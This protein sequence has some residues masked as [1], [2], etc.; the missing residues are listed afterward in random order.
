[1]KYN[2]Y[3]NLRQIWRAALGCV[4]LVMTS[5][6][7]VSQA[8][9]AA[10]DNFADAFVLAGEFGST[11]VDTTGF[12]V[13]GGEPGH[14]GFPAVASGWFK[15]TAPVSG[16]V[17]FETYGSGIDTVLAVYTTGGSDISRLDF[18]VAND[19]ATPAGQ[20][21]PQPAIPLLQAF[22]GNW[23]GPSLVKFNAKGGQTYYV[24]V[25]GK[26]GAQ[27]AVTLNWAYHSAGVFRFTTDVLTVS[28][29]D[30]VT[31][32]SSGSTVR[33]VR[34][35]RVTVTRV[36]GS[37]GR[38][39][40]DL[41]S[42]LTNSTVT[43]V[44][45]DWEMSKSVI[46]PIPNDP[47]SFDNT[48][49][50][51]TLSNPQLDPLE[52]TQILPP[53]IDP[54]HGV[55]TVTVLNYQYDPEDPNLTMAN[56]ERSTYRVREDVGTATIRIN[57]FGDP[58]SKDIHV[59][60]DRTGRGAPQ[61]NDAA[62]GLEAGSDYATPTDP[63]EFAPLTDDP[64]DFSEINGNAYGFDFTFGQ[65]EMFRDI[66]IPINNDT[67]PEFA[68]DIKVRIFRV[69]GTSTTFP[70]EVFETTITIMHDD[71]PAGA[72]DADH[73]P[74]FSLLTDP[75]RNSTPGANGTVLAA[76]VQ[77]D[78]K[79]V[80]GGNFTKFNAFN[81]KM[82]ARLN[83]DGSHD[84]SFN[85]GSGANDFIS[86]VS[87]ASDGKIVIGGKFTSYNG[88][89][90]YC[91]ARLND[92]GSLDASFNP[93][94]GASD[95][96]W[97]LAQQPDGKILI[98]G[99][100]TSVNG[101]TRAYIAR[102]NS[103]GS[104]DTTFNPTNALNG[105][106][107]T[108]AVAADGTIYVGGQFTSAGGVSRNYVARLLADGSLDAAFDPRTGADGPVEAL[109][110]QGDGKPVI[111]GTFD[112]VDLRERRN[113]A[114]LN[115]DGTLD[116]SFDPGSGADDSV[117]A[118]T[119][120]PDGR[121]FIGGAFLNVNGT[122][123]VGVARLFTDGKV[124]T[125]FMDTAYNHF[126]GIFTHYSTEIP[127][128]I[129]EVRN[130]LFTLALQADG[131]LMIGGSFHQVGGGRLHTSIQTNNFDFMRDPQPQYDEVL[132][133]TFG[134]SR[135]AYRNRYNIARL[136]GGDTDGPGNV[137]FVASNTAIDE[138]AGF[139]SVRTVR[140]RGTLGPVETSFALPP[141]TSG[142]GV[143][144]ATTD[145]SYNHINPFF[146]TTWVGGSS[147]FTT[148]NLSD[149]M[150]GTNNIE[151]RV[152]PQTT[153][154]TTDD[155][156]LTIARNS[157][158]QGDRVGNMQLSVP[159]QADVFFLG[160]ENVPLASALGRS[161]ASLQI[162]E[163]DNSP[164]VIG[165][166]HVAYTVNENGGN[167][168]IT[169]T[170]TNGSYGPVSVT[171]Y[172]LNGTAVAGVNY[173]AKTNFS[174]SFGDG[175]TNNQT[176]NIAIQNNPAI[177]PDD[178]TVLLRLKSPTGGATLGQTNA[179]LSIID[180]D[181]QAG[182]LN[183]T[184]VA[185]SVQEYAG[186]ARVTVTRTGGNLGLEDVTVA[187]QN[188]T[189][190]AGVH[191][192]GLTNSLHWD[193]GDTTSRNIDI[194]LLPD[195]LVTANLGFNVR[196][197]NAAPAGALGARTN[198]AVTILNGDFYGSPQFSAANYYF[199]ET[200]GYATITV[201]RTGGSAETISVNYATSDGSAVSSGPVP[202]FVAT[203]GTL[204]FGPGVVS[205]TLTVPILDDGTP[206]SPISF[207]VNLSGVTPGGA[208]L[209]SPSLAAVNIIDAQSF[210]QPAGS[211][212][213]V[214]N[215]GWGFN[216][217]VYALTLQPSGMIVAGGDFTT[218]NGLPQ[219][220]LARLNTNGSPDT[221][222]M[223]GLNGANGAVRA[224]IS[225]SNNRLVVGG[226]FTT[227]NSVNRNNV[228][229]LNTDGTLDT[230][231][232]PGSGADAPVYALAESA[233]EGSRRLYIGGGFNTFNGITSPGLVRLHDNGVVDAAF[234]VAVGVNGPVYAV[235]VYATNTIQAGK[236]VIGGAFTEVNGV[237]RANIA[238]L[239]VDG[240]LDTTFNPGS[241]ANAEVRSV[242]LQ[243]DGKV[244]IGGAF[245]DVAGTPLNRIAR[246]NLN[247][248]VDN[249]F[250]IGSGCNEAVYAVA[251][252]ADNR[253]LVAGDFT[254]ASGVTRRRITRLLPDGQV[255]PTI[256]FG[257]GANAF[258][259]AVLVQ[260]DTHIVLGG[261]FTSIQGQ[262]AD[263]IARIFGGAITGPGQVEFSSPL[264]VVNEDG[265]NAVITLRR[266]L[267]TSGTN[268]DGTGTVT[269]T[270]STGDNSAIAGINYTA[271]TQQVNFPVGEVEAT[272]VVPV[273]QDFQITSDLLATLALSGDPQGPQ[274]TALLQIVNV[275]SAV[276]FSSATYARNEDAIDG[277][278]TITIVREGSTAGT[279]T[280]I[281]DTTTNGT[282]VAGVNYL[283]VTNVT[284]TFLPGES[285]R[286]VTVPLLH[287][288][289][290]EGN[291]TV[292][293]ALSVPTGT[294]LLN[295]SSAI[296]TINDVDQA[297]GT[298]LFSQAAYV[299]SEGATNAVITVVRS[300]GVTGVV[301]V[302]INTIPG[303]A[304]P[305]VR[306]V[307]T[308]GVLTFADGQSVRTFSIGLIDDNIVQGDQSLLVNL[309]GATGGAT[310]SEPT[311]VSLTILDNDVAV[312]FTSP[313]YVVNETA[314]IV[315]LGVQRL[316]GSNGTV[317]V[318]FKTVN[319]TAIAGTNYTADN[320]TLTFSPG[321]VLKTVGI[322]VQR[323]PR[324]TGN[325]S[326][327]AVLSNASAGVQLVAPNPAS[328]IIVDNDP[329]I[330][331]TN[332]T[333]SILESGT[334]LVVTVIR[335]NANSGDVSVNFATADQTAVAGQDYTSTSGILTFL[336]GETE[337]TI[338]IP[339]LDNQ[340]V[341]SDRTFLVNLF[342]PTGGAQLTEPSSIVATIVDNDAG[343]RFST[344]LYQVFENGVQAT[345]TVLR[346][347]YTNSAVSVDYTTQDGTGIAGT[348]YTATSGTLLFTNGETVKT[349]TVGI[350]DDSQLTGD[351]TVLLKLQN[352]Q[353][354]AAIINPGAATLNIS[355]DDG[356]L[357]IPAGT[358]LV[359]EATNNGV[360]DPGETLTV[361]FGFRN[362]GGTNAVNMTA[363]LLSSN[364][365]LP[366]TT[367][368]NYGAMVVGAPVKSRPY[369]FVAN[370]TNGQTIIANFALSDNG[371]PIGSGLFTFTLGSTTLS[372]TNGAAITITDRG[373]SPAPLGATPYPSTIN[374]N[375]ALGTISKVTVTLSNY[376]HMSSGDVGALLVNPAGQKTL[377]MANCG[378]FNNVNN[379]WLQFDDAA[380]GSLSS[381][382]APTSGAYKPT[383]FA[384][385]PPFPAPAPAGT[386]SNS[387]A[388]F[389]GGNPNG[390][391]SLFVLD[392]T[393]PGAGS[394]ANGWSL[395]I[396]RSSSIP[397]ASDLSLGMTATPQP[398]IAA[399]QLTYTLW[400]TNN[401]P[402]TATSVSVADTLPAGVS[403]VSATTATGGATNVSGVVTWT[404]GSMAN[405]ATAS[406]ALTVIPS[407][408]GTITNTAVASS[409]VS[410]LFTQNNTA[411]LV[412]AVNVPSAD[413]VLGMNDSPDPVI[414]GAPLTY[415]ITVTN[416][417]PATATGVVVTNPLLAGLNFTSV[418]ASQGTAG[419]SGG[420]V[421]A[422]LGSISSG[423]N[424]S[425]TLV[426][427]VGFV[428]TVTNVAT[429]SSP[430]IDPLKANNTASVKTTVTPQLTASASGGILSITT[431]GLPGSVLDFT[432]SLTPPVI[433]TPLLTNPPAVVNLPLTTTGNRFFRLRAGP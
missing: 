64:A 277:L 287:N 219:N 370:G 26:A 405:G 368:Q 269:L 419:Q 424:A 48:D 316:N 213:P 189:A 288:L 206:N 37:S 22:I 55:Q 401:G 422:N 205:R 421:W 429:V 351:H 290:A 256:N 260:P 33:S 242:V 170:R 276:H 335:V 312:S 31:T 338:T 146:D 148:R 108:I 40:V 420:T 164:G 98:G 155:I 362:S 157:G 296:L 372:F 63:D 125:G 3:R 72:L 365:I 407:S 218:L 132:D 233:V 253:I 7:A 417:G 145:Y 346:T 235:A 21:R 374:V 104:V 270:V 176:V 139:V 211:L 318:N 364:G 250:A 209:G 227:F 380:V 255:D 229:R 275:D 334:N 265:A 222:F 329:G 330:S 279:A 387:L 367:S 62:F 179:T 418:A 311:N 85:P 192:V 175:V 84:A 183:F 158:V 308:N 413:L 220:R 123:R 245:T 90:R 94:L 313:A 18:V 165:F 394:I 212:D 101:F 400:L 271:V 61:L 426:T 258:I 9:A 224:L 160:G 107:E 120:Q 100:F 415:Q 306:Y 154:S 248:T 91:V 390:T 392:D 114:R 50:P 44:F 122:R 217:D 321:E 130:S 223:A 6:G 340:F 300:N 384:P 203:N 77:A 366:V 344:D 172:T 41:D 80:I 116:T 215:A 238:R 272:V 239:N 432:A 142:S 299:V 397:S 109:A 202:N 247:G 280:V 111:G 337:K 301:S 5:L 325:L 283:I 187:T 263:R 39:T 178:L 274:P 75:V 196:L 237:A 425:I 42:P 254:Q 110:L 285:S 234:N 58:N 357:I 244:L 184:T 221:S 87:L 348:N 331:F 243:P 231:F 391:W 81:R 412:S 383:S 273:Q 281:F 328:V 19:E 193:S 13:E 214:F 379:I 140:E 333:Y 307:G 352:A 286:T 112:I 262:T 127:D 314:G 191:Y 134:Y 230:T 410:D 89:N 180:D 266:I 323:D 252:Q 284:V 295:P 411:T 305:G 161:S 204:V 267:G 102:L 153:Y 169:L 289:A 23:I 396:T 68:E 332:A 292:S 25:D 34:G 194:T 152:I 190:Q 388:A 395:A 327:S 225:Q 404:V 186:T 150:F 49:Y 268:S 118:I 129:V 278:A 4:A 199:S 28:E 342:N 433:W 93:G 369:T 128:P 317:T 324:V 83:V 185:S 282:A 43:L 182:R 8:T 360:I 259:D 376:T 298:L 11:N 53:R 2:G 363:T 240:S 135:Q 319:G 375:G 315:N 428:G 304:T 336:N 136:L 208:T 431:P 398:G 354:N 174:I 106:V 73:N 74:D 57:R 343:L 385:L 115:T 137:G 54:D 166:S 131:N 347:N 95:T 226:Q 353:G 156:V 264:Y 38:A 151:Q 162:N 15:W 1:M 147:Y 17:Q 350:T 381:G 427:W 322:A 197:L 177:Q 138:S 124:D 35:A 149:G 210:N 309:S 356:S 373:A 198:Q 99:E 293:L 371:T 86:A 79:C 251:L 56:F 143:A 16:L 92:D 117:Y 261:G 249:T 67:D 359:S 121:I 188:G 71:Y 408:D 70:G 339:I 119:L 228:T 241:G 171:F 216:A 386:Y 141:G 399:A 163:V 393:S 257:S 291:K 144:Q 113:I 403:F 45:D 96:V 406:L 36:A 409:A 310:I 232:D 416:L 159:S 32:G 358:A 27:G 65:N 88:Q 355:D 195:G 10:N 126:A 167:A 20:N 24:A 168:A 294:V 66:D 326:F 133:G 297:P 52:S 382:A 181:Y 246:L 430:V 173:T 349:F 59:A 303:T 423:G 201:N 341:Q 60:I 345:I 47:L 236:V 200:G 29:N 105:A 207:F 378:G 51:V 302:N 320:R 12:T 78:G 389:N 76:A 402:A 361:L 14:A 414:A 103:N 97:A 82:I 69:P 30:G 377:L 46:L